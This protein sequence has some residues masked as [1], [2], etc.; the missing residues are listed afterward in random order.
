M[1]G[2]RKRVTVEMLKQHSRSGY[3]R[4]MP[5]NVYT[6]Y[7]DDAL[8]MKKHWPDKMK[9]LGEFDKDIPKTGM[10]VSG[11]KAKVK[12]VKKNRAQHKK[13]HKAILDKEKDTK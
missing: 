11:S 4:M 2:P 6:M 13:S 12:Q 5:G 9:I 8:E 10:P 7:E 1:A 3:G